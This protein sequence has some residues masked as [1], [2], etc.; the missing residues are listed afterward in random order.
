LVVSGIGYRNGIGKL[1]CRVYAV[2]MTDVYI[3]RRRCAGSLPREP[4][5]WVAG[6]ED[7][8]RCNQEKIVFISFLRDRTDVEIAVKGQDLRASVRRPM[9]KWPAPSR[10]QPI[11]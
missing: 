8:E 2:A 3:G 1:F 11:A 7:D 4:Q 5:R 9:K 10:P 6:N